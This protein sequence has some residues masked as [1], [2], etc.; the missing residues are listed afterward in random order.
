MF[1]TVLP[2]LIVQYFLTHTLHLIPPYSSFSIM[3]VALTVSA[4]SAAVALAAPAEQYCNNGANCYAG[5]HGWGGFINY[6]P[7]QGNL[8]DACRYN[9]NAVGGT[10][11]LWGTKACVAVAVSDTKIGVGAA[12]FSF[13]YSTASDQSTSRRPFR[14][15]RAAGTRT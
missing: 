14:T 15:S 9:D 6:E 12:I 11:N 4:L 10:G 2:R 8:M 7:Y 1:P 3:K 5:V 13:H